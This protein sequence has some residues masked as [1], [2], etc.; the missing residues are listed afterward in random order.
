MGVFFNSIIIFIFSLM[1]KFWKL[2]FFVFLY[3]FLWIHFI[4]VNYA[5]FFYFV[6]SKNF[7]TLSL[8]NFVFGLIYFYLRFFFWKFFFFLFYSFPFYIFVHSTFIKIFKCFFL[9]LFCLII[10]FTIKINYL[11]FYF[12]KIF[13]INF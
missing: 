8:K 11:F 2:F 13:N 5:Y 10:L 3:V 6:S 4:S 9:V 7:L 12:I 1:R